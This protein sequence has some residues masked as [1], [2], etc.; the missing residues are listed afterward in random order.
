MEMNKEKANVMRIS[1]EPSSLQIIIDHKQLEN[2]E[3]LNYSGSMITN[4]ARCIHEI[5][6]RI[7]NVKAAFN[8]KKNLLTSKFDLNL[9]NKLIKCYIWR[10]A[11][12]GH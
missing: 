3:Y 9:K 12:Y 6:Y 7:A 4:N 1:K 5:K 8:W 11:L 2:V 10:L